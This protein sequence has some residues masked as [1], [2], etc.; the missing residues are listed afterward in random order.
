M[1]SLYSELSRHSSAEASEVFACTYY[2]SDSGVQTMDNK[3]ISYHNFPKFKNLLRLFFK[4]NEEE[5]IPNLV[6]LAHHI[7]A[8]A[9]LQEKKYYDGQPFVKKY[10]PQT[11]V[12]TCRFASIKISFSITQ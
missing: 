6:K 2:A 5:S 7:D 10:Y 12:D 8:E 4:K 11:P 9:I 1:R 3:I